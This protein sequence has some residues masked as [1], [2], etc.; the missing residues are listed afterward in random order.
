[1]GD[2]WGG[3]GAAGVTLAPMH[4]G[5]G[6]IRGAP[7]NVRIRPGRPPLQRLTG[8]S[9]R[10]TLVRDATPSVGRPWPNRPPAVEWR[11]AAPPP[12]VALGVHLPGR[13]WHAYA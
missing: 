7:V 12:G 3:A 8:R 13:G 4:R 11:M 1:M 2:S 6:R 9:A 5:R 10:R